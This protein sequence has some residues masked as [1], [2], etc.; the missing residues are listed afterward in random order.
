MKEKNSNKI[1][2]FLL[3]TTILS[4]TILL[5]GGTFSYFTL[6]TMSKMDALAVSAGKVRL[7]LGVSPVYTGYPIIPLKDEYISVAYKQK[8]KDDLDRGACLAYGLEV[9]NFEEKS[10]IEGIIDFH[11]NG[12]ENLSYSLG[13]AF[14]LSKA[15]DGITPSKK[16]TLLI[17]LTDNNDVQDETDAGK[18]FSA[19]ITY[20]TSEGGRLT[21]SVDGKQA[22]NSDPSNNT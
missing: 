9:F 6:S 13:K 1:N 18:S 2:K 15:V 4:M 16:F 7:G 19:D 20:R 12:L 11:L 10:E 3:V 5:I 21:A 17:W 22:E 14:T 8:C